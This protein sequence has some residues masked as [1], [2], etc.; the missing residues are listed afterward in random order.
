VIRERIITAPKLLRT[1]IVARFRT[2]DAESINAIIHPLGGIILRSIPQLHLTLISVAEEHDD[3]TLARLLNHPDVEFANFDVGGGQRQAYYAATNDTELDDCWHLKRM[4]IFQAWTETQGSASIPIAPVD[5]GL[6]SGHTDMPTPN[7][8][9]CYNPETDENNSLDLTWSNWGGYS[10]GTN[11][12]SCIF[13]LDNNNS[14]V[15]GI[16]P[17]CTPMII[18][19]GDA[20]GNFT[21]AGFADG[22]V[23]AVDNGAK[24][25]TCSTIWTY[26]SSDGTGSWPL[27]E[28]SE[29]Y[30]LKLAVDYINAND[31]IFS[32]AAGNDGTNCEFGPYPPNYPNYFGKY[33]P[34][35]IAGAVCV[36][37]VGAPTT[38]TDIRAIWNPSPLSASNYGNRVD[39][40]A[41]GTEIGM[42]TVINSTKDYQWY[43]GTSFATPNVAAVIGLIWSINPDLTRSQVLDILYATCDTDL[44]G[45]FYTD[46]PNSAGIPNARKAVLAAKAT[47]AINEGEI[48]PYIGFPGS[49]L[50]AVVAAGVATLELTGT[51]SIELGGY[52]SDTITEI[53]V[54]VGTTSIYTGIPATIICTAGEGTP[55]NLTV[56]ARTATGEQ[57]EIYSDI[58]VADL[59]YVSGPTG[60]TDI[61]GNSLALTDLNGNP[62]VITDINNNPL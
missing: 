46:F 51:V 5:T 55:Q 17:D 16:A 27:D 42:A 52:S 37:A 22:M 54:L 53:E 38:H 59:E 6:A 23:W 2:E 7:E 50:D 31:C 3:E 44:P 43:S 24:I 26:I 15:A 61:Q 36:G 35:G 8:S 60:I 28:T 48:Y 11:V 40:C 39:I 49:E 41:P 20:E 10:H 9:I 4:S 47:L 1:T 56:I 30:P 21:V 33:L 34:S 18:S 19:D 62:I 25:I 32:A 57:S 14:G 58:V 45:A 29:F 13:A 12:A